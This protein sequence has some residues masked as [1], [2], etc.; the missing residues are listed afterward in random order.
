VAW[1]SVRVPG[2]ELMDAAVREFPVWVVVVLAWAKPNSS[3]RQEAA[4]VSLHRCCATLV[5]TWRYGH[6]GE[7]SLPDQGVLTTRGRTAAH[8]LRVRRM[9]S[10]KRAVHRPMLRVP[11]T[12]TVVVL[13]P[14]AS[15]CRWE[16][17]TIWSAASLTLPRSV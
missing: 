11:S 6:P 5:P 7:V 13:V 2:V 14:P 1:S 8:S 12:S 15:E 9:E 3:H 4:S 16:S 17:L 10:S